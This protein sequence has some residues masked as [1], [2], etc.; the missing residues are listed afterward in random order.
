MIVEYF[1][2]QLVP[3]LI[4]LSLVLNLRIR[5]RLLKC[6]P[7]FVERHGIRIQRDVALIPT[8]DIDWR[9]VMLHRAELDSDK[10]VALLLKA[11]RAALG[12]AICIFFLLL[13]FAAASPA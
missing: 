8:A 3:S 13:L 12:S 2:L 9:K 4:V 10:R 7:D 1:V 5:S 11:S 6:H